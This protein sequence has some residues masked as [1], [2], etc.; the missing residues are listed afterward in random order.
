MRSNQSDQHNAVDVKFAAMLNEIKAEYHKKPLEGSEKLPPYFCFPP[1]ASSFCELPGSKFVPFSDMSDELTF[2]PTPYV[3]K[4]FV[5]GLRH[6]ATRE[7]IARLAVW[8]T[9]VPVCRDNVII[10]KKGVSQNSG[11]GVIHLPSAEAAERFLSFS[12]H[13][14]YE[15]G[16]VRVHND[17]LALFAYSRTLTASPHPMVIEPAKTRPLMHHPSHHWEALHP[18]PQQIGYDMNGNPL[19][20]TVN[21]FPNAARLPFHLN[22]SISLPTQPMYDTTGH[23]P[24]FPSPLTVLS[25]PGSQ[26]VS[27]VPSYAPLV[28]WRKQ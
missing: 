8:I 15:E 2:A 16:G 14:L 6:D 22:P 21:H 19:Y 18:M 10:F 27:P 23:V 25:S 1:P 4:M 12:K 24:Y 5:G 9:G 20:G 28:T 13:G 7:E 3:T 11:S 26:S 17:P